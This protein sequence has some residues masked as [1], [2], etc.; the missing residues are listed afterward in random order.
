M[1]DN[2]RG[3]LPGTGIRRDGEN[4]YGGNLYGGSTQGVSGTSSGSVAVAGE[5]SS[6]GLSLQGNVSGSGSGG[7]SSGG[8]AS[9]CAGEERPSLFSDSG[10]RL[11]LFNPFAT[12]LS[13][14]GPVERY[15]AE[16]MGAS[17]FLNRRVNE[18][19]QR[20]FDAGIPSSE[21][22][23][24]PEIYHIGT[25][26]ERPT[27]EGFRSAVSQGTSSVPSHPTSSPVSFGPSTP[28]QSASAAPAGLLSSPGGMSD[29]GS[30]LTPP[31]LPLRDPPRMAGSYGVPLNDPVFGISSGSIRCENPGQRPIPA[32]TPPP[33]AGSAGVRDPYVQILE[34]QSAMSMLMMQM[35]REMNQRSLQQQLPQ[36]PQ[37]QVGQDPNQPQAAGQQGGQTGGYQK[38]MK[39]D[40]KW[41]PAMPVPGW[42]S[43]TSRGKELSG[44]KD[45]LEKFSGWLSLIHDAYGPEL[46]ETIHADY[47]IQPCRSPEQ[48]MRS[49]RLFHILQKQ[50]MGYSKIENLIRSRISATG[51]TES[52]GF[53]LLR[54]IRK[55]FS[56]MS[57][58]E[59]LSYRKMRLNFRVKRTEHLLDIIREVESEIESFHAMLDASVIVLGDVRISEGDQFLLYLRNLPSE[60]QEFLQVHR[61][62]VTVQQLKT[63]VQDYYIR[64]RV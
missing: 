10:N 63:G 59:A 46:W 19:L 17:E 44:F 25:P 60:V 29:V 61:N 43:W 56:L 34:S 36:Q 45:W 35:A 14:L 4:L 48:L 57:R 52:N 22:Y 23:P 1:W 41:I 3:Q 51:I 37:Q 5:S 8:Q 31:G 58:T 42:K 33:P 27:S 11:P 47:P 54:L 49:K 39:M 32:P 64:T 30:T 26:S 55:E 20:A 53:E 2:P 38:E 9:A 18:E 13:S 21:V 7:A 24:S 62:A 50:F 15:E 12:A 6:G 28:V 40:E 16:F